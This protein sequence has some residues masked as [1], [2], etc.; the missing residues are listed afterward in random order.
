MQKN[1]FPPLKSFRQDGHEA[2]AQCWLHTEYGCWGEGA[3]V[4]PL[5]FGV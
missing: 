1:P 3:G 2:G 5:N 4:R